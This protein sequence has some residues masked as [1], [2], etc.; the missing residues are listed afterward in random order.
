[1]KH[2]QNEI[3]F[4]TTSIGNIDESVD[5]GDEDPATFKKVED[6]LSSAKEMT[7][8]YG[9]RTYIYKCVPIFRVD[10]GKIRVTKLLT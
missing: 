2:R 4:L 10:R 6:A 8:E 1:M 7:G 9:L 3:I 5:F